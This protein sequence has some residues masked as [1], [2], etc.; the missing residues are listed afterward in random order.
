MCVRA[1]ACLGSCG[2][3]TEQLNAVSSRL[4]CGSRGTNSGHRLGDKCQVTLTAKP[5]H[6]SILQNYYPTYI[7]SAILLSYDDD[8]Y[9]I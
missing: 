3:L 4:L 1:C 8:L 7:L 6:W 2:D 5:S 9:T